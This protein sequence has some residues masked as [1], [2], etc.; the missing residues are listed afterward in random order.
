MSNSIP[1]VKS[2]LLCTAGTLATTPTSPIYIGIGGKSTVKISPFKTGKDAKGRALRNMLQVQ[3]DFESY[4]PTLK[5]LNTF[6]GFVNLGADVQV[7]TDKQ[8]ITAGSEDVFKFTSASFLLGLSF[9]YTVDMEKRT[10]K[11]TLKG[12][13]PYA[14]VMALID[15]ADSE[16][17][18]SV[19]G[20]T[21]PGGEDWTNQRGIDIDA[22]ESPASTSLCAL[23]DLDDLKLSLKAKTSDNAFGQPM[24]DAYTNRLEVTMRDG[25]V[26]NYLAQLIKDIN[27]TIKVKMNNSGSYYDLFSYNAGAITPAHEPEI[28]DDKRNLKVVYEGDVRP[29]EYD[30]QVGVD[31]GGAAADAGLNGGTL[32]IG[33]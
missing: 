33:S 29:Y 7:I 14:T 15:S 1:G 5:M 2:I 23:S 25:S 9:E 18:V 4:Q 27:S 16:A 13:A 11:G 20:I 6:F 10:L 26:T 3:I 21:H 31:K 30:L 17:A 8:S 24:V 12:A 28:S 19:D 22:L 32:V